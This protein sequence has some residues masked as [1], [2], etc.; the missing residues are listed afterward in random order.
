M[1]LIRNRRQL[2]QNGCSALNQR[3]RRL[4]LY[5]LEQALLAVNPSRCLECSLKVQDQRL[6]GD[7]LSISLTRYRRIVLLAVGKAAVPMMEAALKILKDFEVSGISV[8]PKREKLARSVEQ[9]ELFRAGHPLPDQEGLRAA[10]RVMTILKHMHKDELL[11]CL[12]SGGASAMLPAPAKGISLADKRKVTEA[13]VRSKA[14]IHEINAVRRH[15]SELKG[16]R[17]V[18]ICPASKIISVIMSD[19]PGNSLPDIA[20]GLTVEDSTSYQDAV[21]VLEKYD[22]WNALPLSVVDHLTR[23]LGGQIPDTPKPGEPA[24]GHV[25]NL[26]IAENRTACVAAKNALKRHGVSAVILAS[27]VEMEARSMGELLASF[28][29]ESERFDEPLQGK[30][31]MIL[32][33]ESTVEVKGLGLGGRNQ[34]TAL[35]AVG[36]IAGLDGTVIATMGTDGIDGNSPAAGAIIDGNTMQRAKGKGMMP[37]A[38]LA[39]NDSYRFFRRLEDSI[40]TG[41]TNTNVGDIYVLLRSA[42]S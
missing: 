38:Y 28:A 12:I 17:L 19:V 6:I 26:I 11:L 15:L 36:A 13:L 8:M 35:S 18:Q 30:E 20:S 7:D 41:K 14:S 42:Q 9:I 29:V 3:G 21:D 24:F 37:E 2:I 4:C 23:G 40:V 5:A 25:H 16:G 31:A 32:G 34:E 27:S 10:K 22:I 39:K 1:D 33:G